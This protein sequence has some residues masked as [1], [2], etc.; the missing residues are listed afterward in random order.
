MKI[1]VQST[2]MTCFFVEG[3]F[4]CL[5]QLLDSYNQLLQTCNQALDSYTKELLHT[6]A[7]LLH[8][9]TG[10]LNRAVTADM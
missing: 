7:R 2:Y 8:T 3:S 4:S 10:Q 6:K 1:S 5:F 9:V